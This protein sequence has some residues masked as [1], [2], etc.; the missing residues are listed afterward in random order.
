MKNKKIKIPFTEEDLQDLLNGETFNWT[1]DGVDVKLYK[2][3]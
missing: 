1:F 3:E 2:E